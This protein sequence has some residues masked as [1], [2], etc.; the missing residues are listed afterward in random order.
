M[1]DY[2]KGLTYDHKRGVYVP[3]NIELYLVVVDYNHGLLYTA[4]SGSYVY[5]R[6]YDRE[7]ETW[8]P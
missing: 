3:K 1:S 8:A 5:L 4:K 7:K 2:L 6:I